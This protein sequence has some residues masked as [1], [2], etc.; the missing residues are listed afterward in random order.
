MVQRSWT[1][2]TFQTINLHWTNLSLKIRL[3][4]GLQLPSALMT[5]CLAMILRLLLPVVEAVSA[6]CK[7]WLSSGFMHAILLLTLGQF[8]RGLTIITISRVISLPKAFVTH[9]VGFPAKI[10]VS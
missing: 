5:T 7:H 4:T 6:S 9:L 2:N 3:L 10:G 8:Y 1:L